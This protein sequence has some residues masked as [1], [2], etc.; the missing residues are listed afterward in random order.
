MK[1][2]QIECGSCPNAAIYLSELKSEYR[3]GYS[4]GYAKAW[5]EIQKVIKDA[6][7]EAGMNF[8]INGAPDQKPKQEAQPI[9]DEEFMRTEKVGVKG[10]PPISRMQFFGN[11]RQG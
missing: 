1:S 5:G 3:Q 11:P 9:S 4:D 8:S 2:K 7:G 10:F 6:A